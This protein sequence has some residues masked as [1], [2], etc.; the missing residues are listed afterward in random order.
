MKLREKKIREPTIPTASMADIAFLLLVFFMV[1]TVF[2][3]EVGLQIVLPEKGQEV[4]VKSENIQKVYV[5]ELGSLRLNGEPVVQNEFVDEVKRIL[6]S[7][8]EAIFSIKTHPRAKYQ[9][10]INA[11]DNLRLARAERISFAPSTEE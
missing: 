7:N 8:A 6:A 2:A 5:E 1:T 11:F 10:M 9:Y 3:N 4:K